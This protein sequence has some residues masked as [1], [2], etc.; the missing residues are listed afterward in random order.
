MFYFIKKYPPK[1]FKFEQPTEYEIKEILKTMGKTSRADELNCGSCGYK[2]C[3]E[4]AIAF[5]TV[6]E[7]V[8]CLPYMKK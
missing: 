2:I 8:K 5:L 4:K 1:P 6:C 3:R 7:P